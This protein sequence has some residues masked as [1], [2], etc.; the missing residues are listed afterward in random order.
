MKSVWTSEW[1]M[2]GLRS[3]RLQSLFAFDASREPRAVGDVARRVL[4]EEGVVE[5]EAGL[6]DAR[7]AVDERDL[8][9][10]RGALVRLELRA[11]DVRA[12][13]RLDLDDAA[14]L[15]GQLE[16]ARRLARRAR[17]ARV[18]RTV[19]SV[20]RQSGVVKTSSV[21][22]FGTCWRPHAVVDRPERPAGARQEPDREIGSGA[23]EAERVEAARR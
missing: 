6:A 15:E 13:R 1:L 21:G 9:E 5:D 10:E 2:P 14:A 19:P 3:L 7:A 4:V 20:R 11:D 17:A 12:R 8:A 16:V 22:M 18:E 23:A